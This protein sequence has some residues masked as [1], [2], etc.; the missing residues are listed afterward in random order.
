MSTPTIKAGLFSYRKIF[1]AAKQHRTLARSDKTSAVLG[2]TV[3][4]KTQKTNTNIVI[5]TNIYP[6]VYIITVIIFTIGRNIA[7]TI[8]PINIPRPIII[9]GSMTA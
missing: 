6:A 2:A 8:A 4:H 9:I 7:S 1:Q 5:V 3:A